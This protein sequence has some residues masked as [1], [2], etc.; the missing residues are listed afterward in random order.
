MGEPLEKWTVRLNSDQAQ[1]IRAL[2]HQKGMPL[3]EYVARALANQ[4]QVDVGNWTTGHLRTIVEEGTAKTTIAAN[5]A[6]IHAQAVMILL[7]EWRKA[8]IQKAEGLPEE[9]ARQKVQC[10]VN[11]ATALAEEIFEDPRI[12]QRYVWITR[13]ESED[14]L[15]DWLTETDVTEDEDPAEE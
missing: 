8:D 13:P 9:L 11:D 3:N 10:D 4:I 12:Q 2:A 14:D 1:M 5:F 15:P 6:A 7:Q